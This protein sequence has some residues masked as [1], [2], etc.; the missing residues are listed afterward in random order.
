MDKLREMHYPARERQFISSRLSRPASGLILWVILALFFTSGHFTR[1][2]A[3][4]LAPAV[5]S[6][7]WP[8]VS[9]QWPVVS[10]HSLFPTWGGLPWAGLLYPQTYAGASW[11]APMWQSG[12]QSSGWGAWPMLMFEPF[13]SSLINY[14]LAFSPLLNLNALAL[15]LFSNPWSISPR[16]ALSRTAA[17][18]PPPVDRRTV[19]IEAKSIL[20][21]P[22]AILGAGVAYLPGIPA[23][24]ANQVVVQFAPGTPAAEVGRVC[25]RHGCREVY[26]SPYA[27]YTVLSIPSSITVLQAAQR[28]R[29]EA[30]VLYAEPNFLR[31]PHF[32]PNDPYYNYQWHLPR[33][34]CSYAWDYG[35]GAGVLVGLVD[36]GVAFE[37]NATFTQAPDLAGTLFAP[38]YDF[39]NNDAFPDDDFGHGTHMAG[40]IA[41]TTNNLLGVS[42]VAFNATIMPVKVMDNVGGVVITTEVDGI[43]FAVNNGARVISMS[44]GGP[45]TS[46]TEAAAVTYA[47]NAGVTVVCSAGNSGSSTP[48][49]PAS[50]PE[51]ISVS[52]IRY[53][54]TL[55]SYSNYGTFVDV[56]APGGDLSVDQNAD[57]FGDGIL[58]QT[59]NGTD[60]T[61]FYYYF[62]EGTS[63]ACA[64]VSGVAALVIGKSTIPLAP[65]DVVS[66]IEGSATDLGTAGWDQYF[67]FG[68][69]NAYLAVLRTP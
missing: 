47:Y 43:Y 5:V 50:Y 39:V 19:G 10:G 37:T 13:I 20:Y 30:S 11:A 54:Y 6:G 41:Q 4:W 26:T 17:S 53:D 32:I 51:P 58:Q 35:A 3:Q 9:G 55:P 23:Y 66:I 46:A 60:Y 52:S 16:A 64:L 68:L 63:P 14:E 27:G 49:Y 18:N 21:K 48:E 38:G 7:Q 25:T 15:N 31:R 42:G 69:V 57:G 24:R 28:L 2:H 40:C 62:M 59:H 34:N 33:L 45:G 22:P 1:V 67:G 8:V 36:S 44:L 56:C 61:T 12:G 29:A 65:A